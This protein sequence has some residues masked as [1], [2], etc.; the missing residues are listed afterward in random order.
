MDRFRIPN[1]EIR[2]IVSLNSC[3][4]PMHLDA[5]TSCPQEARFP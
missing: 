5:A 3:D 2:I 4:I 1:H